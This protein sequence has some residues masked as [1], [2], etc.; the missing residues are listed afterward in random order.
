[1][2]AI[3]EGPDGAAECPATLRRLP[4]PHGT[5]PLKKTV[6][7][8]WLCLVTLGLQTWMCQGHLNRSNCNDLWVQHKVRTSGT[9]Q[10]DVDGEGPLKPIWVD[11]EMGDGR[12]QFQV[13]TIVHHNLEETLQV[14]GKEP[15]GSYSRNVTY[16]DATERHLAMLIDSM[17]SCQQLV[18]WDCKGAMFGFWYPPGLDS[19]WVG[20]NW[21]DQFYWGGAETDS[22]SCGCHPYCLRTRRNS[23]CNCDANIKQMWLEDAGL[24][25][26]AR[27]L[28]VLQLRFGDTG[29]ANEA[30]KHTL[31]PLVCRATGHVDVFRGSFVAPVTITSSGYPSSYP[32]PFHRYLWTVSVEAGDA[33]ELVFLEYDV[34][35]WG[36]YTA[37]PGCR[38]AVS[39]SAWRHSDG[40]RFS[41]ERQETAPPYFVTDGS[42]TVLNLTLTT[43][44]QI[45]KKQLTKRGF[46]AEFRRAECTGCEAGFGINGSQTVCSAPCGIIS[47][48]GYPYPPVS[49]EPTGQYEHTWIVRVSPGRV[50]RL[51]Y[52]DFDVASSPGSRTCDKDWG[53]VS[54]YSGKNVSDATSLVGS[55][56]N[57]NRQGVV[58]SETNVMSIVFHGRFRKIGNSRGFHATYREFRPLPKEGHPSRLTNVAQGK[59]AQQNTTYEHYEAQLAVDEDPS[60]CASTEF[61]K[62]PWWQVNLQKEH[63]VYAV[64]IHN[65]ADTS[66]DV[67]SW[68]SGSYALPMPVS[69]CP[70]ASG[71]VWHTGCR[72]HDI[73]YDVVEDDKIRH[74]SD[75]IK[76]QGGLQED[77]G[78]KQCFCVKKEDAPPSSNATSWPPGNYCILQVGDACPDGFL[79][80]GY[81]TWIDRPPADLKALNRAEGALPRGR[82]TAHNTTLHFCCRSDGSVDAAIRLPTGLPFYLLQYDA[83][84]CQQVQGMSVFEQ[85][86]H[87]M[88]DE[89]GARM[90]A[91]A[92]LHGG[93]PKFREPHPRLDSTMFDRGLVLYYCYYDV[94]ASLRGF[95]VMVDNTGLVSTFDRHYDEKNYGIPHAIE[96]DFLHAYTCAVYPVTEPSFRVLRLNCSQPVLGQYVTVQIF[97][98]HDTL[99]F[100]EFKVFAKESCGQPLGMASEEIF[101]TQLH[102]SSLDDIYHFTNARLNAE[103]GWCASLTDNQKYIQ[104]D[105]QNH[106][107][108]T[109]VILQGMNTPVKSGYITAFQLTF[110]N[111]SIYWT[112]EEQP[113][114][115]RKV[116][117]CHQ[118][119]L[120]TF[121]ADE[122]VR[123]NLL[124]SVV[125]RYVKLQV[126]LWKRAPCLRLELVGCR[127]H[128]KCGAVLEAPE[129]S[130]SS[131]NHPFYYGQDKSCWW[132]ILPPRG[133]HVWLS[134]II[135]DLAQR[136]APSL[137][138]HCQ[139]QLLLCP[140]PNCSNSIVSPNGQTFPKEIIS[141][142]PMEIHLKTCFRYSL[143]RFSGFYATYKFTD[144]PGCSMGDYHC[145]RLHV[146]DAHCGHIF[147]IDYPKPYADNHRCAWLIVAPPSHYINVTFE[148]F[149]LPSAEHCASDYLDFYDG[150]DE[151]QENLIGRYCNSSMPPRNVVSSWNT[152]TIVFSTEG[153]GTGRGFALSYQSLSFQLPA[154]LNQLY[155]DNPQECPQQWK[156]YNDHCY[157]MYEESDPLQWYEAEAK[158]AAWGKGRSGHLVSI[159]DEREMAII[160]YFLTDIWKAHRK[161]LYI[162]LTDAAG[163]GFYRWSDGNPMSYSDWYVRAYAGH[164]LSSQ[165]DW[166]A[167]EDCTMLRVDSGHS[168]AH[169]HDIPCSLGKHSLG[170]L[171]RAAAS[172]RQMEELPI[173]TISAYIC[174]M[175]SHRA[176]NAP[177]PPPLYRHM[178]AYVGEVLVAAEKY[179]VCRNKEVISVVNVCDGVHDCRDMSDESDC[180]VTCPDGS[181][182]CASGKCVSI[183]A[184]CDF[185]DDCG[186]SSD[187]SQCDYIE[188][189]RTEFRCKNGQCISI[190]HRCDLLSDCHDNSD[191]QDCLGQCNVNV[192][193]QCYDGTCI[194]KN[195][196]CDGHRDCPGKYH[197]DEQEGCH[198]V[199]E[200]DRQ[201]LEE[202]KKKC[203]NKPRKTCE[204]LFVQDGIRRSGHY[205]I[206]ADGAEGPIL[207]FWVH[208]IM[209]STVEDV[210][211]LVHHDS[212]Q[213][214]Y[215]RSG[216]EGAY[217]RPITYDVGWLQ[218]RA[219]ISVSQRCRQYVKWE[220]SGVGAGFGYSDER[221]LSWWESAQGEPQFHWGGASENLTCACYPDCFNPEQRCNCDSASEFHWLED[222]GY[223][224]SKEMLPIRK[225]HFGNTYRTG[226]AGYHTIGPLEC[227]KQVTSMEECD[228]SQNYLR[229]RTGHFVNI[230]TRCLYGFDQFGFQAGCRD[231]SHLRGCEK[232]ICP[233]DYVKCTRSYCI[234]S[235]FLCDGKWDC[236]GG[237][238]EIECN[239]YTCPGRYKCRNQSSC[240]AL[241]QLCDGT[242]QCKHGDDEHLCDL[243][244]PAA[245]KCRGHF[246]KCIEKNLVALPDD[247]SHLV[248]KLNFSFNRLDILKSNFSPFKRLGELILQYNGLTVL[249]SNKFIELK[250][251]YL[252]DLRNNRIVQIETAAFAGLKNVRFLHLEN[253][254][255]LSEIKAGAF[256]GLNKLTFLNLSG[257]A[258]SGLKKNTFVGLDQVT[259]LNL[260]N[261]KLQYV[262][263]GA[264]QG[265]KSVTSLDIQGN[266]I[267]HFSHEMFHGLHSLESLFS[268]SFKF[269]C[270]A[271]PQVSFDY[272]LPPADEISSCEDLMSSPVQRS[273]LWVLGVVALLGNLFV[274]AWR[275]KTK[276]SNPV[277]STLILS[278][279]CADL[280]MGVY[281][282]V[283]ASVDIYYRGRYI[284]NSDVWR[285]SALCKLCGFLST[286]SSESSIFTL[287]LI[288]A[289]RLICISFPFSM[290]R[291]GLRRTYQLIAAAWATAVAIAALPLVIQPYFQGEF[292]ARSGVC[293]ALHITNQ[294]PSGWE[295]SVAVF[296]CLNLFAFA[297]IVAA[298]AYMYLSIQRS[299]TAVKRHAARQADSL[300][301]R[302]MALIVLT[303]SLCWFPMIVMGLMAMS[304]VRIPGEAYAW[305]A[306]FV[307]PAN[308]AANPLI[309]T[310]AS[311]RFRLFLLRIGLARKQHSLSFSKAIAHASNGATR[312]DHDRGAHTFRAPHGYMSLMQFLRSEPHV[313]PHQLLQIAV[314]VCELICELH[315]H[316]YA[317][318]GINI[319]CVFV[320]QETPNKVHVYLPDIN[321]YRIDS[322]SYNANDTAVD[323]EEFGGLVKK[324]LRA[325]HVSQRT[326]ESSSQ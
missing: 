118:C 124:R 287:V 230:S 121:N 268:D 288:T 156:F 319:D 108:I 306:V 153:K 19:W 253:N 78:V 27:R 280:L 227:F 86:F 285:A 39:V 90:T 116:Y 274:I 65:V 250:N 318:G 312:R 135:F 180:G 47:S 113:V 7:R 225:L 209:G 99:R 178:K 186:D 234:P 252:L 172:W 151:E 179:F 167:Y 264:F 324:M 51:Q 17:F 45:M 143:S 171:N 215:V 276:N 163:E 176:D 237:E 203:D 166:V 257:M 128:V 296:F 59:P 305:T 141:N 214:I 74:W 8:R 93:V 159:L 182:R 144:C 244:C 199:K 238:D 114:G 160:H 226:Q 193:F 255:I 60:S 292:Y 235:H 102:A 271:S 30:G 134:F 295:Y 22:R 197:E 44:N 291:F 251:L 168:T 213:R 195:A 211:T 308:S 321:A 138:G 56:C 194:P 325:Y 278:L 210:R 154:D 2:C 316:N 148:D 88:E 263:D 198:L 187:E 35:H 136:E 267:E 304:G 266:D 1:M 258:L 190:A 34:L 175:S 191:E 26:D 217:A 247:L 314:G 289:D 130:I 46:M 183:G 269:C 188:C 310:I 10:I 80:G 54:I 91:E 122:A 231:V 317:L 132:R 315:A 185:K 89:L 145:S 29:E 259:T 119:E 275:L 322:N 228:S 284:Q 106:T 18:R 326:R 236:I 73:F 181:F 81:V 206:D 16:G 311:L 36:A 14:R 298:Y 202:E 299:K 165:P 62:D 11:C 12:E 72:F 207:P 283:I 177:G 224:T 70:S 262:E 256:V 33:M 290:V 20:R 221:P 277:S 3:S 219:L 147:S 157:N 82:Y 25:L 184:F 245:C 57:L 66:Q 98:R 218:M 260:R 169:W 42:R 105:L 273:F 164:G 50:V 142:G 297:T 254:P 69:G 189:N 103:Y 32:P 77:G 192:T 83:G 270:L 5:T 115:H 173:T 75:G 229:C 137:A 21:K 87:F 109:G 223:I 323:M 95:R 131:P 170:T 67:T 150:R 261:N 241:H 117:E 162:G 43:C 161:S 155:F 52:N 248:R 101:D 110:S 279:G 71:F 127:S 133:K 92:D 313:T 4:T 152:L 58:F 120:S 28:P 40:A 301:G 24:L 15:P 139:D 97:G 146:C 300:V 68:P 216:V 281:L 320:T 232:V 282:V 96:E 104:I 302:Q 208:C 307:L 149:D 205:L 240:V 94:A 85:W 204:D 76:L 239:K 293:L 303:N 64:E 174:K 63:L 196:V 41:I 100:C 309:Y 242:R 212:E 6:V 111:D 38:S 123:Y 220:C 112:S 79:A 9:Y 233:E 13:L 107:H 31:G 49:Y 53:L 126:L 265:L 37:V 84:A 201:G 140:G 272:C 243:K 246:V 23:T 55:Y 125:T 129:G 200:E 294:K 158:C 249:P 61:I 286:V 48:Y 222:Q